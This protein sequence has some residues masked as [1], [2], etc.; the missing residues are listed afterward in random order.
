MA[1]PRHAACTCGCLVLAMLQHGK[2]QQSAS[3]SEPTVL[4]ATQKAH[5]VGQLLCEVSAIVNGAKS[6]ELL[7]D[8]F[9]SSEEGASSQQPAQLSPHDDQWEIHS[10]QEAPLNFTQSTSTDLSS[11]AKGKAGAHLACRPISDTSRQTPAVYET[12]SD[13][14]GRRTR[15]GPRIVETTESEGAAAT[16]CSHA[17]GEHWCQTGSSGRR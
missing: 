5:S 11:K 6:H 15:T 16:S 9:L 3:S 17:C 8:W 1:V 14:K 13:C 7:I 2:M 4:M 12:D 10:Y